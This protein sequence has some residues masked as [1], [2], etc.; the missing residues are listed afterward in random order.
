MAQTSYDD[1]KRY[2][3]ESLETIIQLRI[4][5][6]LQKNNPE[7]KAEDLQK[8]VEKQKTAQ[9]EKLSKL[10][11]SMVSGLDQDVEYTKLLNQLEMYKKTNGL[12]YSEI[13]EKSGISVSNVKRVF[14]SSN[15]PRVT[16]MIKILDAMGLK[17]TI[18]EKNKSTT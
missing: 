2:R 7:M 3:N 14:Y 8:E 17:L 11:D 5:D 12:K 9:M 13:A 15:I 4:L 6:E 18:T 16:T 1:I 10:I